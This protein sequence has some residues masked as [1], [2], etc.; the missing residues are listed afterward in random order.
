[1]TAITYELLEMEIRHF[2]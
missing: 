2:A 1:M